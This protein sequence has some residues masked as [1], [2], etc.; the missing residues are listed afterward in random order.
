MSRKV[1]ISSDSH[2]QETHTFYKEYAPAKYKDRFPHTERR[3]GAV[4]QVVEGRKPRRIDI[5]ESRM[6]QKEFDLEFRNDPYGGSNVPLRLEDQ[7]RDGIHG[8]VVYPNNSLSI[9]C[10]PDPQ[11][12]IDMARAYNDWITDIFGPHRDKL[13]PTAVI[14]VLD[15]ENAIDEVR[16]VAKKGFRLVSIPIRVE[17]PYNLP[18]WE[19]LWTAIEQEGLALSLHAFSNEADTYPED[20]GEEEGIGGALS[21]MVMRMVDGME[22]IVLLISCGMLERHPNLQITIVECGAGW[23]AWLLYALDEQAVKKHMWIAPKLQLKPSEYFLRQGHVTFGDDPAGLAVLNLVPVE[24]LLWGSDYPHEE[25]TFPHSQAVIARTFEGLPEE[26]KWK[27]VGGNA[28]KLYGFNP[29][30]N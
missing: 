7:E 4:Y 30:G 13:A 29:G 25:G 15:I 8:E 23:L 11:Y 2:V 21:F 27:I 18:R 24:C 6:T 19:P 16:R 28:I 14:P 10:S 9:F 26:V 22:P 20:W 5:A 3:N 1:I 12:Q 17:D